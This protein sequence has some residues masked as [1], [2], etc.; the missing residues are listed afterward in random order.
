MIRLPATRLYGSAIA[1][2]S[3]L[4]SLG[5]SA[6]AMMNVS[7]MTSVAEVLGI[8]GWIMLVVGVVVLIHGSLLLTPAADAMGGISGPLMI[9]WAAIMLANQALLATMP[10]WGMAGSGMD[11]GM[12]PAMSDSMM[13][14]DPGM[15][16]ISVLM[17]ASGLI[18]T[19]DRAGA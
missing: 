3:G 5:T 18:M 13:T 15:V 9:V 7:A 8:G 4:Y 19:R 16:A 12:G 11:G 17:L 14:A 6:T 2:V 1:I 10:N